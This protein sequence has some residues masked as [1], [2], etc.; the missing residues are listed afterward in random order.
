MHKIYVVEDDPVIAQSIGEYLLGWGY[1]VR[2]AADFA[3][4]LAEFGGFAPQLV[5]L[6]LKLPHYNGFH[7]CRQ[8]RQVSTVPIVFITSAADNMNTVMAMNMGADDL[9]AKPFDLNVL[10]AKVQALLRRT[11]DFAAAA[12][13]CEHKGIIH[14]V[15]EGAAYR[16][17]QKVDLTRNENRILQVLMEQKG[18]V[19]SRETLMVRLWETDSYVDE[20]T[21]TVNVAR[22]R[23]KLETLGAADFIQTRKGQGYMVD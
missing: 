4:V 11:Y 19:V 18:R 17:S 3:A 12:P 21:L 13:L 5:L 22:L 7:W 6:D 23:K 16:G 9:I 10:G 14:N 8:I 15:A 1:E 20:N 2:L